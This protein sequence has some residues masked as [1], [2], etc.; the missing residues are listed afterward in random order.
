MWKGRELDCRSITQY[1]PNLELF[2]LAFTLHR[3]GHLL[4]LFI[5]LTHFETANS[6]WRQRRRQT[7][8][9]ISIWEGLPYQIRISFLFSQQKDK[10]MVTCRHA[11]KSFVQKSFG[12]IVL[13]EYEFVRIVVVFLSSNAIIEKNNHV[14][15]F[16]NDQKSIFDRKSKLLSICT[17]LFH[18]HERTYTHTHTNNASRQG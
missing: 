9:Y 11:N 6:F 14:F 13:W 10:A 1:C 3:Y 15:L 8:L 12:S 16:N 18:T 4:L 2:H 5:L 7:A 17:P